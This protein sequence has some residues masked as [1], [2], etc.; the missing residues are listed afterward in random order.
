MTTKEDKCREFAHFK[1]RWILLCRTIVFRAVLISIFFVNY[2]LHVEE[3]AENGN[4]MK[5]AYLSLSP[6]FSFGTAAAAAAAAAET[7]AAIKNREKVALDPPLFCRQPTR[8]NPFPFDLGR[9]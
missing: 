4:P 1:S 8:T 2:P 6:L 3:L 5:S 7:P 9:L